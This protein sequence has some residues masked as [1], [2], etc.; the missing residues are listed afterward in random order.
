MVVLLDDSAKRTSRTG[1]LI[2][3]ALLYLAL[4]RVRDR[5]LAITKN[6]V[7]EA[8]AFGVRTLQAGG[9]TELDVL[10]NVV[11]DAARYGI[12]HRTVLGQDDSGMHAKVS[13]NSVIRTSRVFAPVVADASG[14]ILSNFA[15]LIWLDN[16]SGRT[17]VGDNHGDGG[18]LSGQRRAVH[19]ATTIAGV[20]DN[21]V[22]ATSQFAFE[23]YAVAGLFTS[24]MTGPGNDVLPVTLRQPPNVETL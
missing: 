6:G 1:L 22:Q 4:T 24:N 18:Q 20:S 15:A 19:V 21:H 14:A 23:V 2:W 13:R 9:S 12:C 8:L 10:D 16:Q 11:S 5:K 7:E 17:L 3:G